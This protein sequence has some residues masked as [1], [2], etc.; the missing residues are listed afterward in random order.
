M[1]DGD[2]VTVVFNGKPPAYVEEFQVKNCGQ[3]EAAV[4]G[5]RA[6]LL[7]QDLQISA[8]IISG[9]KPNGFDA[10]KNAHFD[11]LHIRA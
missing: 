7:G 3:V 4:K 11:L 8:W 2:W 6:K 10:W 1:Y 5:V 9:R